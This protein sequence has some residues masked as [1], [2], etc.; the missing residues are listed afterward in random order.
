ML[1]RSTNT[2][3]LWNESTDKWTVTNDGTN[4]FNIGADSGESYANA[5]FAQA[6]T[7][8]T[9]ATSAGVYGNS[10]FTT[11]NSAA[12]YANSS[13]LAANT[14][15]YVANSASSYANSAFLQANT[16]SY[17]ANSAASYANAAFAKA[18]TDFTNISISE[19]TYGNS[20][21]H[22]IIT[23]SANGRISAISNSDTQ[24]ATIPDVLALSIALG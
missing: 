21:Y 13:F 19:A 15:S 11:A 16:P 20:Y 24:L 12:S 7:G 10:A 18:N 5:A 22:P 14:P 6:N 23:V 17:V 1:F 9:N 2:A 4:Y 3:L 8:S